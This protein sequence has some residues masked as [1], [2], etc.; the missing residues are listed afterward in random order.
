MKRNH[1]S[2]L[3]IVVT[4]L[5]VFICCVPA[6]ADEVTISIATKEGVGSYLVST[7]GKA[8]YYYKNDSPNKS[9][10]FGACAETWSVFC[11]T[12]K[13]ITAGPGLKKADFSFFKRPGADPLDQPTYKGMPLYE[14]APDGPGDT[15]GHRIDNLWF[16]V[17]P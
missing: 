16:L 8:L 2:L 3:A 6:Q 11:Y 10:C 17:R 9:E 13:Q 15:K 4:M 7:T 5:M 12:T 14:Y 1:G